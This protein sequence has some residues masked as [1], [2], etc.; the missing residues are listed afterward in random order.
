MERF[1]NSIASAVSL[2][3]V[4]SAINAFNLSFEINH[5]YF[6]SLL[7]VSIL[8]PCIYLLIK[9]NSE[10][11]KIFAEREKIKIEI[12]NSYPSTMSI[13]DISH[14]KN[15]GKWSYWREYLSDFFIGLALWGT[16]GIVFLYG[17][18]SIIHE[19]IDAHSDYKK[20]K[21]V[22][23]SV[24]CPHHTATI[25]VCDLITKTQNGERLA[26]KFPTENAKSVIN[27]KKYIIES[28]H[29]FFGKSLTS[30]QQL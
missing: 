2:Y 9:K 11:N 19:H 28:K 1:K 21:V 6:S 26:L 25:Q 7:V 29:S 5:T 18:S 15:E 27:G 23:I 16:L 10:I 13:N 20:I 3:V 22:A 4:I 8:C 14:G 24:Q 12:A 30:Y 17:L